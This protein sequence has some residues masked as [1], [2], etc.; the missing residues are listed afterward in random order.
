VGRLHGSFDVFL[1]NPDGTG[2][3]R[4]T[5]NSGNNEEPSWSP[6]GR[7]IVFTSTRNG[8]RDLYIMSADGSN[9]RRLTNNG[10]DNYLADWS[11]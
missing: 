7:H 2:A 6:D 9:Q 1:M 5:S 8:R 10:R 4:L 11:P 3:L